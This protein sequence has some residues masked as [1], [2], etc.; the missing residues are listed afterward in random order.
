M[1][2]NFSHSNLISSTSR[3][4]LSSTNSDLGLTLVRDS[5]IINSNLGPVSHRVREVNRTYVSLNRVQ[6]HSVL[7]DVPL[8]AFPLN[9]VTTVTEIV[10]T[11]RF[12][13][14]TSTMERM[15][16]S[17]S[18]VSP[19]EMFPTSGVFA[20]AQPH[21]RSQPN[22]L[23]NMNL[24]RSE[25]PP[26]NQINVR[27]NVNRETNFESASGYSLENP[28]YYD[29]GLRNFDQMAMLSRNLDNMNNSNYNINPSTQRNQPSS[30]SNFEEVSDENREDYDHPK[31]Y[32][33]RTNSFPGYLKGVYGCPKCLA[34]F[35]S[36]KSFAAHIQ[37]HYKHESK[38]ERRRRMTA[39]LRG[40]NPRLF[41]SSHGL[42]AIPESSKGITKGYSTRRKN[43][44]ADKVENINIVRMGHGLS[45]FG[46][47]MK[48]PTPSVMIKEEPK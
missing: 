8:L 37:T 25:N 3:F 12:L 24:F 9:P 27:S 16:A 41:W 20:Q 46:A 7:N 6:A 19:H 35:Y 18:R 40:R 28:M 2:M 32:D 21:V 48:A 30:N 39:R 4:F 36:P 14:P 17:S 38:E 44:L 43:E 42:T 5:D 23:M 47:T 1:A 45:T 11:T 34:T 15:F 33:G 22:Q 26:M 29:Q 31:G 13:T 10:R